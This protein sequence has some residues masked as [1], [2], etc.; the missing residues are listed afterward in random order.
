MTGT[1]ELGSRRTLIVL[2]RGSCDESEA[3]HPSLL[4]HHRC[5]RVK[6]ARLHEVAFDP[7]ERG[8]GSTCADLV[9][10]QALQVRGID[11]DENSSGRRTWG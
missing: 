9:K 4:V 7:L 5:A 2:G 1:L 6:G 8:E 10:V 3:G 11:V